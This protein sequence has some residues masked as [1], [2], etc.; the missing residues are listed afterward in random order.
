MLQQRA[1]VLWNQPAGPSVFRLGLSCP[2]GYADAIPGQFVM[3][4]TT[5]GMVPL[6][7]RPFSIF[8]LIGD[9]KRPEGL[10]LLYRVIGSGTA[11]LARLKTGQPLDVLGPLGRGFTLSAGMKQI[12]LAAGGMG[13]APIRFLAVHLAAR[14][15]DLSA[16]RLFLGGRNQKELFCRDEF[17]ALGMPVTL[18]TDD[19]SQGR[20]CL[21]TDPLQELVSTQQPDLIAACGPHGMLVCVAGIAEKHHVACQFSMET[22]MACGMGACLGCAVPA[23]RAQDGYRHVCTHGPVFSVGEVNIVH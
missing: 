5:E 20:Q 22:L 3:V 11:H 8:G 23:D 1:T 9:R 7:R 21:L 4:Q 13:V 18:S 6:L 10:E 2:S 17:A 12:Y 15:I 19:G 14:D 16:C